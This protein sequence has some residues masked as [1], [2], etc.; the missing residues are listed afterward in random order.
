ELRRRGISP[1]DVYLPLHH[2]KAL[3]FLFRELELLLMGLPIALFGLVNHLLPYLIVKRI[4]RALSKDKDHWATNVV[5]PSFLVFPVFYV[6]QLT[7]AWLL[8]P[9]LWA[10]VYTLALPYS[11]YVAVLYFER[12]L[13]TLR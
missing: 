11:G 12:A 1:A 13:A 7:A 6:L 3:F 10:G 4:A 5:Y 8:L 2:G 9:T